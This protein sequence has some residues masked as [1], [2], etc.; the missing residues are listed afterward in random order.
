MKMWL[1]VTTTEGKTSG[2]QLISAL[3]AATVEMTDNE[4]EKEDED[5]ESEEG[6]KEVAL[7][8]RRGGGGG[9]WAVVMAVSAEEENVR[10]TEE[11]VNKAFSTR[12]KEIGYR[13]IVRRTL[14][15]SDRIVTRCTYGGC[16]V[17]VVDCV[18]N[19]CL[20]VLWYAAADNRKSLKGRRRV[21][22]CGASGV[23]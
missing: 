4:K 22:G 19:R 15:W 14:E 12:E 17:Y 7:R 13:L 21:C 5:E 20:I 1:R 2:K 18:G 9:G 10:G 11:E 23:L 3:A 8:R 16:G 6:V